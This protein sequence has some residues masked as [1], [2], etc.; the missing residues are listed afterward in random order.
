MRPGDLRR[1]NDGLRGSERTKRVSGQPFVIINVQPHRQLPLTPARAVF[2]VGGR[3]ETGWS[4][5]WLMNN[6]EAVNETG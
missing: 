1:F 6:S 5:E 3:I 4:V 2:L